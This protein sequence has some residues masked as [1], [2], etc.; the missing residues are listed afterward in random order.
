MEQLVEAHHVFAFIDIEIFRLGD[1]DGC[2]V[3]FAAKHLIAKSVSTESN[4]LA[5]RVNP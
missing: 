3:L 4:S 2:P 5:G 1:K